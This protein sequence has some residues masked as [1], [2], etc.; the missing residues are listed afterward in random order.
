MNTLSAR[1]S[2]IDISPVKNSRRFAF[3]LKSK[4]FL[5]TLEIY[6]KETIILV[7]HIVNSL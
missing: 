4:D 1:K 3:D 5:K 7:S 6:L 2:A